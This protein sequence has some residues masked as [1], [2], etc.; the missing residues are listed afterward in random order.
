MAVTERDFHHGHFSFMTQGDAHG[1]VR[2]GNRDGHDAYR[3][4][5]DRGYNRLLYPDGYDRAGM[6]CGKNNPKIGV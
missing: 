4:G 3:P 6:P 2:K 1:P 5:P